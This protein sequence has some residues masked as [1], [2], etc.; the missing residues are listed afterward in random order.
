LFL[1]Y[2]FILNSLLFGYSGQPEYPEIEVISN[3][4]L[5]YG[6]NQLSFAQV[7]LYLLWLADSAG[8]GFG[9][10]GVAGTAGQE[11]NLFRLSG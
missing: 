10:A 7:L 1:D 9:Q 5:T 3:L 4:K 2:F 6:I 8:T 11:K